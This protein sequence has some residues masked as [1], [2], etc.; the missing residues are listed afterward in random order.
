MKKY[1]LVGVLVLI[2][3]M[4]IQAIIVVNLSFDITDDLDE[5][6]RVTQG[7]VGIC[8][9][10]E[11]NITHDCDMTMNHSVGDF[12]DTGI[13]SFNAIHP[14]GLNLTYDVFI[15]EVQGELIDPN[16]FTVDIS[17]EDGEIELWANKTVEGEHTLVITAED[18]SSCPITS[19][20]HATVEVVPRPGPV[21]VENIPSFSILE[22]ETLSTGVLLDNHFTEPYGDPLEYEVEGDE[23]MGVN[24]QNNSEIIIT[25]P[26]GNCDDEEIYFIASD[27]ENRTAD[28]NMVTIEAICQ[29]EDTDSPAPSGAPRDICEPEWQCNSWSECLPTG[30]RYRECYD[31]NAC[32]PNDYRRTFWEEC[33]YIEPEE[34][35]EEE[36]TEIE[37]EEEEEEDVQ[38]EEPSPIDDEDEE[39]YF[40]YAL[41][42][43]AILAIVTT[44]YFLFR[45]EVKSLY[46]RLAWYLTKKQRKEILLSIKQ[47]EELLKA[48][49]RTADKISSADEIV[50]TTDK[51]V[52][53]LVEKTR[54]YLSQALGL[55]KEFQTQEFKDNLEKKIEHNSLA[56]SLGLFYKK[57]KL[58]ETRKAKFQKEYFVAYAQEIRHFI[59]NTSVASR[60]D[61]D[62]KVEEIPLKGTPRQ[63]LTNCQHNAYVALQFARVD[64]A[65]NY[66]LKALSLYERLSDKDKAKFNKE[67][68][69]LYSSITYV[70]SWSDNR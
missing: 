63:I 48:I 23:D 49:S 33:E 21:L 59:F 43:I 6:A 51:A 58:L 5:D 17:E 52:K 55:E 61:I 19:E 67:L 46:A 2:A 38:I 64:A 7:E 14:L 70:I 3:I 50:S 40:T 47:K 20:E 45:K 35:E 42:I 28:S 60:K 37:E 26:S 32:D 24:I 29:D 34:E 11:A 44:S 22:G 56:Y 4:A 62:F 57:L 18:N 12:N 15:L 65:K 30:E 69:K 53:E 27:T 25:N 31:V 13:C 10:E 39:R 66:Y 41:A 1:L 8:I 68:K 9:N 54:I 36:P 16:E